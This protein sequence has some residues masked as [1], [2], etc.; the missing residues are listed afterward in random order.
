MDCVYEEKQKTHVI[1]I[2]ISTIVIVILAA[3]LILFDE[4]RN[5]T[6]TVIIFAAI[7][8][9]LIFISYNFY[10]L[11]ICLSEN[12]L[13]VGFG[14][15]KKKFYI[16]NMSNVRVEKYKFTNYGGYGIRFGRDKS[17]GFC[18]KGG[19]GIKFFDAH[20]SKEFF[21]TTDNVEQLLTLLKNYGAK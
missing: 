20:Y 12:E 21:F 1:F 15:F 16:K 9:F 8:A 17:R 3:Q 14:L 7:M 18:A 13:E 4:I 2:I 6:S 11:K 5:E 10:S 19:Q